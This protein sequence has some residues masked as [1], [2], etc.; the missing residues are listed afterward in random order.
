MK[1][2]VFGRL[3][4][5]ALPHEWFTIGGSIFMTSALVVVAALLTKFRLWKWLWKEWLTSVDPKKI[6]IMYFIVAALMLARGG[7]DAGMLW[8]QQSIAAS[9]PGYL[10]AQHFQEIFTAHGVI[11]VFFVTMGFLFGFMNYIIPLQIGARD[12]ASPFLNTLGFWLYVA[13][14][15][16]TNTFFIVG[17]EFAAAGWLSVAPLSG[18]EYSPGVGMDYWIWSLQISGIGTTLGGIN[19]ILTI[20]K[21]RAPGMSLM[22]MPIFTWASLNSM[23]M[24]VIIFPLLTATVALLNLDRLL[25]MHFFTT[26]AGGNAM[27]YT[28]LIW[29]WGHPEVYVLM[30]PALGVYSE[31]VSVFSGKKLA[32]Y[33]STVIS[34]IAIAVISLFVWLHHFFTMGSGAS[35]NAAF[36]IATMIIA[37]PTTVQLFNWAATMFRGRIRLKVP[38]LWFLGFVGTF[39]VGGMT[40]MLLATPPVDFQLHNSLFL[41]AHFHTMVIGGA[42]FGI[43]AGF[44]YWFPKF[45]G[46]ML[47]EELGKVAFWLWIIGFWV[48]FAP[49]YILGLMGAPRRLESYD[50]STGWQP[51]FVV[52]LLG[53]V[54]IS[55]GTLVIIYQIV[56][57][58]KK[59]RKDKTGDPWNGRTLEWATSSPPPFYNFAVIPKVESRDAFWEEKKKGIKREKEY[60]PFEMPK[61]TATGIYIAIFAFLFGFSMVWHIFWL[62]ALSLVGAICFVVVRT[63]D[64][65]TEYEVEISDIEKTENIGRIL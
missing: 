58:I 53:F 7:L 15:I 54:L 56:E 18:L 12:L 64:E 40:G 20:L 5:E 61:G 27:M 44:Y 62:A 46:L 23:I 24:V 43:F 8:L 41:V 59:K 51:M 25:G 49:L 65:N 50:A 9:S 19:F 36:G 57:A 31:V 35:V 11:M 16:L 48:S 37:I 38:M 30:I 17:G 42:L 6:G 33:T 47:S 39:S 63:F 4:L 45:T 52:S 13:G 26:D 32:N 1:E 10:S 29:M 28:N 22:R 34:L 3:T 21:M 55:L 60:R 14:A 2:F